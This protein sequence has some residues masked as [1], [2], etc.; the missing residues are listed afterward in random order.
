MEKKDT[1][2]SVPVSNNGFSLAGIQLTGLTACNVV[3][4]VFVPHAKQVNGLMALMALPVTTPDGRAYVGKANVLEKD[5]IPAKVALLNDGSQIADFLIDKDAFTFDQLFNEFKCEDLNLF[6]LKE[7]SIVVQNTPDSGASI[8]L[9]GKLNMDKAPLSVIRDFLK[10]KDDVCISGE[11][12]I[13]NADLSKKIEPTFACFA[14]SSDFYIPPS[15]NVA[16]KSISLQ[17]NIGQV[18]N[19]V[20]KERG[21][22]ISPRLSGLIEVSNLSREPFQLDCSIAYASG[23][24][25]A[26]ATCDRVED[27]FGVNGLNIEEVN[28]DVT[29]GAQNEIALRVLLDLGET[30]Y[31]L[32]GMLNGDSAGV[33]CSILHFSMADLDAL[34]GA[35]SSSRLKL[36][37]FDLTFDKV[38]IGIASTDYT[39]DEQSLSKGLTVS[40]DLTVHGHQCGMV[41]IVS[42]DGVTAEGSLGN[43]DI[44]PVHLETATLR[45]AIYRET[46]GKASEFELSGKAVIEGIKVDCRVA[47]EKMDS[48]WNIVIYAGLEAET[49]RLSTLF[50]PVKDTFVDT[51]SFS[52]LGFIYSANNTAVQDAEY[53]FTVSKGLQ[54]MG[55]LEEIPALSTLTGNKRSGL[56]FAAN[57]GQ[58]TS[59]SIQIPG[60]TLNMG[61]SVKCDPLKVS[62]SVSPV[63]SF[64]LLFGMDLTVPKQQSALHFDLMLDINAYQA[65]GSATMKN[66]WENPFGVKGLKIGPEVALQLGII[67]EQFLATGVPSEF[68]IAGGLAI[69]DVSAQMALNIA[70]DPSKEILAGSLSRLEPR[71]L[72]KLLNSIADIDLPADKVPDFFEIKDISMYCAPTGGT[73]GTITYEPGFSFGGIL[74]L[75]GKS[76]SIYTRIS[77][78]GMV[79]IGSIDAFDIGVLSIKGYHS[80]H[81]A[82]DMEIS[83]EK[84][85][86]YLDGA[87][88]F[89]GSLTAVSVNISQ[90]AIN[91]S[92][93]RQFM[94]LLKFIVEG[95]SS[96]ALKDPAS[97][98]FA[99]FAEMDNN[100]TEFLKTKVLDGINTAIS[101]IDTSIDEAKAKVTEAEK[102]YRAVYDKA[103]AELQK[104]E[105]EANKYLAQCKE[106]V[107][108]ERKKYDDNIAQA[109]NK[110]NSA[111]TAYDNA[112]QKAQNEVTRA[113]KEYTN[114]MNQARQAVSNAQKDYDHDMQVAQG[115]VNQAEAEYNRAFNSANQKLQS[116]RNT[117]NSVQSEIDDAK[118][119]LNRA[120]WY[121]FHKEVY[122][123]GKIATLEVG[124]QA[125]NGVL[126][127]CQKVV[128]GF[129]YGTEYTAW[130]AAKGIL[131]ATR[132]GVKWGILEGA[133][134]TLK[135]VTTGTQYVAF[136]SAKAA[137]DAVK[138]GSEYTVWQTAI[139]TLNGVEAVGD[140]ALKTAQAVL[141][142]VGKSAVYIAFE[143]ARLTLEGVEHGTE[144]AAF[145]SAKLILE[146]AKQGATAILKLSAFVAKHAGDLV[147][148]KKITLSSTLKQIEQG[149][150]FVASINIV[151]ISSEY[152]WTFDFDVKNIAKFIEALFAKALDELEAIVPV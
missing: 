75:F 42:G 27:F 122:Y 14:T 79:A 12:S 101:T 13:D 21:W 59:L 123:S 34:F 90:E 93:E 54:L 32:Y 84:Q 138:T 86:V 44:G 5:N 33:C 98:D 110:V 127:S 97:L 24:L 63:P 56:V 19:L 50:P 38:V 10:C 74:I 96:G 72:V 17:I 116:A 15:G 37:E 68:G 43:I 144:Y 140:A 48:G 87:I 76:A 70:E 31:Q 36:P 55:V 91:F 111:K 41:L 135:V 133:N 73:I 147:D 149:A 126:W 18:F 8:L 146:G 23:A 71:D 35:I 104:A 130:M 83:K 28:L 7:T 11:I 129:Q 114:A 26:S 108:N 51:L 109:R 145:E 124:M 60:A 46:S 134:Q 142:N 143:T 85:L 39:V 136:E 64:Q 117:V 30:Q 82:L 115:K 49:F 40:C 148:I 61:K 62:L 53:P 95:K 103:I 102:V 22:S 25:K 89:L 128:E 57:F 139:Q 1:T 29:I 66:W 92:F 112:L 118:R 9:N 4:G 6:I 113:E 58:T 94:G 141:D 120:K 152:N 99:L 45:L 65:L 80:D 107:G 106:Q 81:A 67:Y 52:K 47:Y 151:L 100:I 105:E 137:L 78:S 119:A 132:V 125:A 88:D 3:G 16:F 150:L 2:N 69:G 121:E 77:D 131:E 20:K